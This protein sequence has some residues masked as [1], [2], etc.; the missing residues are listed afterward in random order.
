MLIVKPPALFHAL[1][2]HTGDE[3]A[4]LDPVGVIVTLFSAFFCAVAMV[5][6]RKVKGRVSA[7]V[8]FFFYFHNIMGN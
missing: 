5:T 8:S 7:L 1:G 3:S 4:P 6:I 2:V